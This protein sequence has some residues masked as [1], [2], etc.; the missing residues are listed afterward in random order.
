MLYPSASEKKHIILADISLSVIKST[1]AVKMR[2]KNNLENIIIKRIYGR[3]SLSCIRVVPFFSVPA[4]SS[5]IKSVL[6]VLTHHPEKN[7][8]NNIIKMIK[9]RM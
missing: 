6:C 5:R 9:M 3:T 1:S 4:Q 7:G 8:N 2:D